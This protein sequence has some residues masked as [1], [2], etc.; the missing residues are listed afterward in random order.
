MINVH[1]GRA[2]LHPGLAKLHLVALMEKEGHTE[3]T[4]DAMDK[5]PRKALE[6][7]LEETALALSCKE[8]IASL[9]WLIPDDARYK[10]LKMQLDN[11]FL[12]GEQE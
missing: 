3:V 11:N 7:D 4:M 6:K 9:Y 8:Y 10:P 2:G 12:L 1:G 5:V